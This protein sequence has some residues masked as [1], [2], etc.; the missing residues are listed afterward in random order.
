MGD[1]RN[2][3]QPQPQFQAPVQ[4]YNCGNKEVSLQEFLKLKSLKFTGSDS[5]A[6]SQSFLDGTFKA[7]R[8]LGCSSERAVELALY[9]LK[10]MAN[11]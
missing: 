4:T 1:Q 9:K 10:D 6:D 2:A 5:S 7:L 11:T 3:A 8:A